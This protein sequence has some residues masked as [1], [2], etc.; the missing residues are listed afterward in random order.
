MTTT[1]ATTEKLITALEERGFKHWTKGDKDRMYIDAE[2]LGL[3]VQKYG[4][5]AVKHAEWDGE[6]ISNREGAS[7]LHA[8]TYLDLTDMSV[9]SDDSD[10]LAAAEAIIEE[11]RASLEEEEKKEEKEAAMS[12]TTAVTAMQELYQGISYDARMDYCTKEMAQRI[13][14]DTLAKEAGRR[15]I[16]DPMMMNP[17]TGS[18]APLSDWICDYMEL[19][20]EEWG[21][22]YFSDAGLVEVRRTADGGWEEADIEARTAAILEALNDLYPSVDTLTE[23]M[24]PEVLKACYIA[25]PEAVQHA[26]C[27]SSRRLPMEKFARFFATVYTEEDVHTFLAAYAA[28]APEGYDQDDDLETPTPWCMP[29]MTGAMGAEKG[30][31]PET[32]G[33]EAAC[34]D[35]RE[36]EALFG[37]DEE[38][39]AAKTEAAVRGFLLDGLALPE[40]LKPEGDI[41]DKAAAEIAKA[42]ERG[43]D[44]D[45]AESLI[46]EIASQCIAEVTPR[47]AMRRAR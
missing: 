1:A 2:K 13:C 45:E 24:F 21:G 38:G 14:R 40:F 3:K 29:W 17:A 35:Y 43:M 42:Q 33:R 31:T 36:L 23:D 15:G 4:S 11:T 34:M 37:P 28:A 25:S 16:A 10:L 30:D 6:K 47:V 32:L 12:T 41:L 39:L 7:M 26:I 27:A 9:H 44:D 22:H 8:K 19:T 20:P 46:S 18:V 5:G